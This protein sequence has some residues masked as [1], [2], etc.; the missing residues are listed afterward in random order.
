MARTYKLND[1]EHHKDPKGNLRTL[2]PID[3]YFPLLH[4]PQAAMAARGVIVGERRYKSHVSAYANPVM[5]G[6]S[7]A[8]TLYNKRAGEGLQRTDLGGVAAV[9]SI[10]TGIKEPTRLVHPL[11]RYFYRN[12]KM[13]DR[14]ADLS[15][16]HERAQAD[17]TL[18]PTMH[19]QAKS[20]LENSGKPYRDYYR[21]DPPWTRFPD[22]TLS[23]PCKLYEWSKK[24]RTKLEALTESYLADPRTKMQLEELARFLIAIKRVRNSSTRN[25][26]YRQQPAVEL[27][28]QPVTQSTLELDAYTSSSP[29]FRASNRTQTLPHRSQ[30]VIP[31]SEPTRESEDARIQKTRDSQQKS[32]PPHTEEQ[33]I[34]SSPIH[35]LESA[36]LSSNNL[37]LIIKDQIRQPSP[38]SD[39]L[40]RIVKNQHGLISSQQPRVFGLLYQAFFD[41]LARDSTA[42]AEAHLAAAKIIA[43][44]LK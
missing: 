12:T 22:S 8:V 38:I 10:G 25:E 33:S 41:A 40:D 37:Y 3:E 15:R 4:L 23:I 32:G 13:V 34:P 11:R 26:L 18:A 1:S 29:D 31:R 21:F 5:L 17:Q 27:D 9:I 39:Y 7:E 19:E 14:A 24:T 35:V 42:S 28:I 43:K 30:T 36:S 44:G 6:I 16:T 20:M 2:A